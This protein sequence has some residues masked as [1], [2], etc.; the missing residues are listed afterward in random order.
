MPVRPRPMTYTCPACRW[1]KTV[2]PRSDA[3]KPGEFF[4][5]CPVCG[6]ESLDVRAASRVDVALGKV[7][8]LISGKSR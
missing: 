1:A 5:C 4:S 8:G 2:A 3:L 6:H 7:M